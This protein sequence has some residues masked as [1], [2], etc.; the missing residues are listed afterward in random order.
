MD[1]HTLVKQITETGTTGFAL[2]ITGFVTGFGL[3]WSFLFWYYK[4]ELGKIA[5]LKEQIRIL[6]ARPRNGPTVVLPTP[7]ETE[8][9]PKLPG[10]NLPDRA[11]QIRIIETHVIKSGREYEATRLMLLDDSEVVYVIRR[12]GGRNSNVIRQDGKVQNIPDS[13]IKP[14]DD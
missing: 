11:D 6:E 8:S 1:A 4:E 2:L 9:R 3:A 10:P 5:G 14:L 7:T 13:R 12:G